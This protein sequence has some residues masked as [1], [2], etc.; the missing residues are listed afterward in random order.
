[1]QY[2]ISLPILVEA[3]LMENRGKR[4]MQSARA[5]G[6][7]PNSCAGER[8]LLYRACSINMGSYAL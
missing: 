8:R 1:M 6:D 7:D 5:M 4:R 2:H 3:K